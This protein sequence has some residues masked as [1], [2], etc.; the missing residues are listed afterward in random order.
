[1]KIRK[2]RLG[3]NKGLRIVLL[4][5]LHNRPYEHII[6]TTATINPDI[7]AIAGDLTYGFKQYDLVSGFLCAC[8]NIAPTFVSLGN[9]DVAEI[10][11][12]MCSSAQGVTLLDNCHVDTVVKGIPL[13]IGG[14]SSPI[15]KHWKEIIAGIE[16]QQD[17]SE[18]KPQKPEPNTAW[19]SDFIN[20]S[21]HKILLC[22]Q[23]EYYP[24]HL[25][26]L[27]IDIILAGHAHGGQWR[28]CGRGIYAPGQGWFPK[29]TSGVIDRR[30]VIGRGLSN[31]TWI[32]R[33]FNP[34]EIV[35]VEV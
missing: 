17:K 3:S 33:F 13:R 27:P 29:L 8:G 22:H 28:V 19:L 1:M 24:R 26:H 31:T 21:S 16:V 14:L 30:L 5:D 11:E 34:R 18:P 10:I 2:Y 12:P 15:S 32:P 23:P 9:H 4:S 25:S 35:V 6:K 7:I 20:T